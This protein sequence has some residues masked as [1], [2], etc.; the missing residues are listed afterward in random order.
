MKT[1]SSYHI[2]SMPKLSQDLV[3][4]MY[5]YTIPSHVLFGVPDLVV[6]RHHTQ[7]QNNIMQAYLLSQH[8]LIPFLGLISASLML[9]QQ[10]SLFVQILSHLI[11]FFIDGLEWFFLWWPGVHEGGIAS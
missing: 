8:R 4:H 5:I 10:L 1:C 6:H 3:V 11:K 7:A 9:S 2:V